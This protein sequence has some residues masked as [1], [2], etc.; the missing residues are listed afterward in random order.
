MK[1]SKK[2][3][4]MVAAIAMLTLSAA[5]AVTGTVAWFTANNLVNV[6]GMQIQAEVEN[7]IVI[8]NQDN[9]KGSKTDADWLT[10]VTATYDGDDT[11][12]VPTSTNT[13]NTW[14]HGLSDKAD[15]GQSN[16]SY[17]EFNA[18]SVS[19][20]IASSTT[21]THFITV[22]KNIYLINEFYIQASAKQAIPNQDLFIE[23]IEISGVS[24]SENLDKSIRV[25]LMID[26]VKKGIF[27]P[28]SGATL[29]HKVNGADASTVATDVSAPN[30]KTKVLDNVSIPAYTA[31]GTNALVC[32][33]FVYFEGEDVAHKSANITNS[34]DTLALSLKFSNANHSA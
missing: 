26:N 8:S 12:F 10:T 4:A 15:N 2:L 28:L 11:T 3:R 7:G 20:G 32:K 33:V 17:D 14:Y 23:Q 30:D 22:A 5:S 27:A 13:L 1:F 31:T 6:S 29:S 19:A 24:G 18:I 25:G 21:A 16:V 34:L 9:A